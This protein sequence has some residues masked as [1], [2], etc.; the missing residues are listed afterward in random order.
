MQ[1]NFGVDTNVLIAIVTAAGGILT[2]AVTKMWVMFTNELKDCKED[3][4]QLHVRTEEMHD[5][6]AEIS[7]SVGHLKGQLDYLTKRPSDQ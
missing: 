3:R 4:K 6:I 5:K 7:S 2:G 1:W